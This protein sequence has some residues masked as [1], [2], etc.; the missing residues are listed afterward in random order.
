MKR[1]LH[2]LNTWV[3]R[4]SM[5]RYSIF[6]RFV[7]RSLKAPG[8]RSTVK[9]NKAFRGIQRRRKG[10]CPYADT[11]GGGRVHDSH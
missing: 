5:P 11:Q 7:P 1:V 8:R 10:A 2:V 4:R 9:S 3:T 6:T